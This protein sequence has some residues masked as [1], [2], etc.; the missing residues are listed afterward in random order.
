[1][2]SDRTSPDRNAESQRTDLS[3]PIEPSPPHDP[4]G[5]LVPPFVGERSLVRRVTLIT[6]GVVLL[7]LGIVFWLM[8]VMTGIPFWVAGLIC[9]AKASEKVRVLVN[10]GDRRLPARLR[11]ILRWARDKSSRRKAPDELPLAASTPAP[12]AE[13]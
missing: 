6:V 2:H 5:E 12:P 9:L 10:G 11:K 7:F 1:M 8:P 3:S 4:F 13:S